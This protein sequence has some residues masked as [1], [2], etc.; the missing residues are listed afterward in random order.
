MIQSYLVF[1]NQIY[2]YIYIYILHIKSLS[3]LVKDDVFIFLHFTLMYCGL[4]VCDAVE[5]GMKVV[6][7]EFYYE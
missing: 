4:W 5:R 6:H 3:P 7:S 2:K 1:H